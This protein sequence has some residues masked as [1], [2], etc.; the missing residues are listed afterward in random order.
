[1]DTFMAL[2]VV[3]VWITISVVGLRRAFGSRSLLPG[4]APKHEAC[5]A[6]HARTP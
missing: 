2:A 4:C 3:G 5:P 1:M 6:G